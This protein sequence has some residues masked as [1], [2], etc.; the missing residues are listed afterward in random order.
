MNKIEKLGGILA[1]LTIAA[2]MA[3]FSAPVQAADD[4]G[5]VHFYS[6]G[7]V[8]NQ[9]TKSSGFDSAS[10]KV[11]K[12]LGVALVLRFQGT[13]TGT[14]DVVAKLARSADG[15]NFETTPPAT[16]SFTNA[17]NNATAVVGYHEISPDLIRSVHSLKLVSL[18]NADDAE[19]ITN[20]YV[21]I[22][23]KKEP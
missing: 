7:N 21:G 14:G 4:V 18:A 16:L 9:A 22:V 15:T 1:A 12:Q 19:G 2:I 11:D 5:I 20:V 3:A 8:T 23:K 17:L 6:A 10:V 13:G